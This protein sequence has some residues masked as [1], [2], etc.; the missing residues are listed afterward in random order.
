M[1]SGVPVP[2]L[3]VEFTAGAWT[4]VTGWLAGEVATSMHFGRATEFDDVGPGTGSWPMRNDSGA[5]TPDSVLS[6]WSPNLVE[7]KRIRYSLQVAGSWVPGFF[8]RITEISPGFVQTDQA[9]S[10][11]TLKAVD[12]LAD[13]MSD[14]ATLIDRWTEQARAMARAAGSWCDIPQLD[15]GGN[16]SATVLPNVGVTLGTLGTVTVAA[17]GS[18]ADASGLNVAKTLASNLGVAPQGAPASVGCWLWCDD[19]GIATGGP[20]ADRVIDLVAGSRVMAVT[21]QRNVGT[22]GIDLQ[23][24]DS[25]Y[26]VVS[27]LIAG[28]AAQWLNVVCT[29][30]STPTSTD[31]RVYNVTGAL[32]AS[33]TIAADMRTTTSTVWHP[34]TFAWLI[35]GVVVSGT[36]PVPSSYGDPARTSTLA[37]TFAELASFVPSVAWT[38]DG[39]AN[40]TIGEPVMAGRTAGAVLQQLARTVSGVAYASPSGVITLAASDRAWMTGAAAVVGIESDLD[41]EH[42]QPTLARSGLTR[43]TRVTVTWAG[44]S[45]TVVDAVAEAG[46]RRL[47][48]TLDTCAPDLGTAQAV[49]GQW[50]TAYQGLRVSAIAVDLVT[51]TSDLLGAFLGLYPTCRLRLVELLSSV[52]GLPSLDV[53]AQ[54]WSVEIGIDRAVWVF[55]CS[56]EAGWSTS[57][58]DG[59]D[60]YG[61]VALGT[62]VA[63]VTG[64]TAVGGTGVGTIVVTSTGDTLSTA[65]GDYPMALLWGTEAVMAAGPPASGSSPQTLTLSAR[66]V[67]P[68]LPVVHVAGE[69]IEI[70]HPATIGA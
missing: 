54:G 51:A 24:R 20:Y 12:M 28:I 10:V 50:L 31:V 67:L 17:G 3:E 65:A 11:T 13:I 15:D 1:S 59:G 69:A 66:G 26:T 8:G 29:P 45:T 19:G 41:A 63:S 61:R 21:L 55:D 42:T 49:A 22:G 62:G 58:V 35:A 16:S 37:A 32:V 18:Y 70:W 60:A 5:W 53:F 57:A 7:G 46:G 38:L 2:K 68:T 44:G 39:V 30:N 36:G 43:P 33:A 4:D 27:T 25:G 9:A 47:P 40:P 6:P 56:P 14:A 52:W 48:K 64:G 34:S 23:L